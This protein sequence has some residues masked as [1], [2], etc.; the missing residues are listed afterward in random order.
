MLLQILMMKVRLQFVERRGNFLSALFR[1]HRVRGNDREL[2]EL[3]Q[4]QRHENAPLHLL[5]RPQLQDLGE[6]VIAVTFVEPD[7]SLEIHQP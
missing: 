2:S 4:D 5:D 7:R 3:L 1:A 6:Q